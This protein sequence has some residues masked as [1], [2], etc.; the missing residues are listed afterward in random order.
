MTRRGPP[1]SAAISLVLRLLG[2]HPE[3]RFSRLQQSF[4]CNLRL[5]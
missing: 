3:R 1:S 4:S 2:K 5:A